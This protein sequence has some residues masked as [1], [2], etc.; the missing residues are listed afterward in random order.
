M[1]AIES[2]LLRVL[3][4]SEAIVRA[5]DPAEPNYSERQ[6][7]LPL[8]VEKLK[9]LANHIWPDL[10]RRYVK[11]Y[12]RIFTRAGLPN[13]HEIDAIDAWNKKQLSKMTDAARNGCWK[14]RK[15]VAKRRNG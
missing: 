9:E 7:L 15:E 5:A 4:D 13:I 1:A 10:V 11:A 6:R 3:N 14:I 12:E 8:Q 2:T